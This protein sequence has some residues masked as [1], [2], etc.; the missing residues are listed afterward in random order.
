MTIQEHIDVE[1]SDNESESQVM[2]AR[3]TRVTAVATK[4]VEASPVTG[5]V[6]TAQMD[7]LVSSRVGKQ[8]LRS[9]ESYMMFLKDQSNNAGRGGSGRGGVSVVQKAHPGASHGSKLDRS[10]TATTDISQRTGRVLIDK[11][12]GFN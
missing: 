7:T 11:T 2:I 4:D 10:K 5:T 9:T 6:L 3:R 1:L 8:T 12:T